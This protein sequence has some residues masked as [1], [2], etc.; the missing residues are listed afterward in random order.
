MLIQIKKKNQI[1]QTNF[2]RLY[3]ILTML[4]ENTSPYINTTGQP[5]VHFYHNLL[6]SIFMGGGFVLVQKMSKVVN[7][8]TV[9]KG[10]G[11]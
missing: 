11:Q 1:I 4:L 2:K 6:H 10:L 9:F 8:I 7:K 5:S 3:D